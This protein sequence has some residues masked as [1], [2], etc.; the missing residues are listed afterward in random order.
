M[1]NIAIKIIG[2]VAVFTLALGIY[3]PTEKHSNS[4]AMLMEHGN[5]GG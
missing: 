3:S 5:G 2:I 4:I 1:K